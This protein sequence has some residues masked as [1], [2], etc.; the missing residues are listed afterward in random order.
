MDKKLSNF[1]AIVK[2][3]GDV[4]VQLVAFLERTLPQ[5]SDDWW[6]KVVLTTLSFS[7][8][9]RLGQQ[10]IKALSALDLAGL[11][12]VLDQNWYQISTNLDLA[13]EARNF[14]KEMQTIRNRWAH[15]S[16]GGFSIDDIYRDVD[17][18]QRF[19]IVIGADDKFIRKLRETK[20]SLLAEISP[21]PPI[22]PPAYLAEK[23]IGAITLPD[24][25]R[26]G[27]SKEYVLNGVS[28]SKKKFEAFLKDREC[29]VKISLFYADRQE[30]H[31]WRVKNF[32]K[33]SNL[34]GN[35]HSG[36]LRNWR[37][38]GITGIKLEL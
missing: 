26:S 15:A 3:L 1:E 25:N 11:L 8:K 38:K 13:F 24:D 23:H 33:T 34:S 4:T 27:P 32:S 6:N 14:I 9:K 18:V 10:K 20:T 36:Y 21:N 30:Q 12:R 29:E 19:A 28:C 16:T 22:D 17:T 37:G 7:Q 35:L 5:L 2:H 31:I